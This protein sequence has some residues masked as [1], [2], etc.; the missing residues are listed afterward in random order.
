LQFPWLHYSITPILHGSLESSD[1]GGLSH[2]K[3]N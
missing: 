1:F 3:Q 2:D